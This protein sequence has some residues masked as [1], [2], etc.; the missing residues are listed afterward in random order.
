[1]IASAEKTISFLKEY[2]VK[3]YSATLQNSLS[4]CS[5]NY[6]SST[7]FVIGNETYGLSDKWR[8]APCKNINIP[9]NGSVD[10]L[11]LSVTA[12]ILLFEANRQRKK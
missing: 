7:A 6:I 1:M 3:I 2:D 10:S 11:N 4:Y 8:T 5:Q 12:A 9:M